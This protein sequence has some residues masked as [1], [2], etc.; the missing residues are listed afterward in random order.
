MSQSTDPCTC[1]N[2]GKPETEAPLLRL[3]YSGAKSWICSQC[4]PVLIHNPEEVGAKLT[5]IAESSAE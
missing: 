3:R 1:L 2:C 5:K 4:M